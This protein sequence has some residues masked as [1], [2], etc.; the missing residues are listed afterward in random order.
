LIGVTDG[1]APGGNGTLHWLASANLS[2][3]IQSATNHVVVQVASGWLTASVNGAQV[4]GLMVNFP[5]Q[6][7]V[8]FTAGTGALTNRHMVSNVIIMSGAQP[9][10]TVPEPFVGSTPARIMDTRSNLGA[11][12]P[13]APGGTVSLAVIGQGGVPTTAVSAV[14]LNVTV[15]DTTAPGYL[16]VYPDGVATPLASNLNFVPGQTVPNL[17]IAPVGADGKVDLYNGSGGTVQLVAD[18]SGYFPT[19]TFGPLTPARI[20]DTRSNLGASGPVAPWGTVSFDVLGQGGVPATGV[21]AVVLNVTVTDTTA[22][23][24]ITVYPDGVSTPLASN[25]NFVPGQTVPNLVIAPVGADGKV[26]FYNGS[27]ATVQL[28]ADTSG[29]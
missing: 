19:G 29:Y 4:L 23:G 13:V 6:A 26:D 27:S 7:L 8:G 18:V 25:L 15:T 1:L 14:V 24:F 20:M 2:S 11:S 17:V 10:Q 28:V 5:Q 3:P 16:T 21:S 12:G 22:P 9:V